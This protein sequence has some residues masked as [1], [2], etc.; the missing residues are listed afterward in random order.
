MQIRPKHVLDTLAIVVLLAF[1]WT[2]RY[3]N[4]GHAD[5]I[6]TSILQRGVLRVGTDPGFQPFAVEQNGQ[7][8]GYDVDLARELARRL[9][10]EVEFVPVGFDALYDALSTRR[11]DLLAAALPLAPEQGWRARFSTSY[12]NAGQVLVVLQHGLIEPQSPSLSGHTIGVALGTDADTYAR[13]I[14]QSDPTI[15]VRS[16]FESADEALTALAR[17]RVD[18]VIT[19]AVTALSALPEYPRLTLAP[20]A[21]TFEPY[22]LA[23]PIEGYLLEREVNQALESMRNEGFFDQLNARWFRPGALQRPQP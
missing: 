21:L 22:V 2:I 14:S 8:Q 23:V 17:G 11:V 13:R 3:T 18:A 16:D 7:L 10:V 1:G 12:L 20:T 5:P 15:T 6:W 19:D 4:R 9:N